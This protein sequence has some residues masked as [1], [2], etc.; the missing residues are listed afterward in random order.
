MPEWNTI[1]NEVDKIISSGASIG[2]A[3]DEIRRKY[4]KHLPNAKIET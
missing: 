4:I 2:K 3:V 1:L